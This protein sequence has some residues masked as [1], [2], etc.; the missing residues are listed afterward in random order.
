MFLYFAS[1]KNLKPAKIKQTNP[2][3]Q[4]Q[5]F[6]ILY[7]VLVLTPLACHILPVAEKQTIFLIWRTKVFV[8]GKEDDKQVHK[9]FVI[10][11]R[12]ELR[13]V[14][15]GFLMIFTEQFGRL[16]YINI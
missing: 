16:R 6:S 3:S 4:P 8:S 7:T 11:V 9:T 13:G 2:V 1:T 5:N 12:F 15:V 14:N 10:V